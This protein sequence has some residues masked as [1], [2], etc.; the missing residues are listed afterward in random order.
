MFGFL[1]GPVKESDK[2]RDQLFL[3][4]E[5]GLQVELGELCRQKSAEILHEFAGW[6]QVPPK[7][8]KQPKLVQKYGQGLMGVAQKMAEL[9]ED[10][11]MDMLM[12]SGGES[13][14]SSWRSALR[15]GMEKINQLR[16]SEAVQILEPFLVAG[17]QGPQAGAEEYQAVTL[18]KLGECEYQLGHFDKAEAHLK[19]AL[20]V[21]ENQQDWDG[22]IAYLGN[23]YELERYRGKPDVAQAYAGKLCQTLRAQGRPTAQA[24][25]MWRTANAPPVR[26]VASVGGVQMEVDELPLNAGQVSFFLARNRPTLALA[27]AL[28]AQGREK[29]EQGNYVAALE[30][31]SKAAQLDAY[32]PESRYLAGLSLLHLKRYS[33][34]SASYKQLERLAPGWFQAR[35]DSWLAQ[36]LAS[37][38]AS[39]ELWLL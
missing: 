38:R 25:Q 35:H 12:Q 9:G 22:V 15:Q 3:L 16:F 27:S 34:A 1:K 29:A 33:E 2:T 20:G 36:E 28:T 8:R 31:F 21:C 7:I 11:P 26:V 37:G 24:D 32:E 30:S 19:K 14:P 5:R 4:V 39:H 6:Q 17:Q 23:L 10:G 13:K 18:G